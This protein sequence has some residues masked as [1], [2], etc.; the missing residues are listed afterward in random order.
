MVEMPTSN[1]YEYKFLKAEVSAQN[2][3]EVQVRI[4]CWI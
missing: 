3:D 2:E 1:Q 4:E